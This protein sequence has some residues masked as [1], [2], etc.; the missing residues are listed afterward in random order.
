MRPSP[1]SIWAFDRIISGESRAL[2]VNRVG[3]ICI[4]LLRESGITFA[5]TGEFSDAD[6]IGDFR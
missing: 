6:P 2:P 3:G 5:K 1:D 4:F